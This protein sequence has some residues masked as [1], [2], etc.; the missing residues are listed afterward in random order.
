MAVNYQGIYILSIGKLLDNL[1]QSAR[2]DVPDSGAHSHG[3]DPRSH[4]ADR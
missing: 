3:L 4:K 1:L 2:S